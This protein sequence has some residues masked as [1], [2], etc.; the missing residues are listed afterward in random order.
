[1]RAAAVAARY[2]QQEINLIYISAPKSFIATNLM[3]RFPAW[4]RIC[5]AAPES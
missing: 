4:R 1:M 5:L 2:P 3:V